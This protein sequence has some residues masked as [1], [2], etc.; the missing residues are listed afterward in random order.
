MISAKINE[1]FKTSE[2]FWGGRCCKVTKKRD[3]MQ[4]VGIFKINWLQE[5]MNIIEQTTH[6]MTDYFLRSAKEHHVYPG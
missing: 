5:H 6:F 1:N 3:Y 4:M 2:C